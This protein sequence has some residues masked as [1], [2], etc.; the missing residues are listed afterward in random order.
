[1]KL[2]WSWI[3]V[4]GF[5][6]FVE[7]L[8]I[9]PTNQDQLPRPEDVQL[10][11]DYL[12]RFYNLQPRG[13]KMVRRARLMSPMEEKIRKMQK[14][15]GL[16]E[17]G[18]L[19]S[20]TLGV[21]KEP[22]CGVPDVE[23]FSFFSQKPKWKKHTITY[24]IAKYT[25]D[26]KREDV[27]NSF[28]SAM[29][30]W[31][32]A[33]LLRFI[34]VNQG[35]ADIVLSFARRTHGDFFPFDGPRGVLAHA[36]QPG[37]GIG[38]DV[39]FDED[40]T[41]TAGSGKQGYSLLAVAA[42]EL[43]HSLGLSHS[44]DPTAIMYPN[45]KYYSSTKCSLA[46][47]DVLGIQTLYGKPTKNVEPP[48][49]SRK[50]SR[51]CDPNFTLDAAAVI[52]NEIVFFKNRDMWMR[53]TWVTSWNRLTEG[54]IS[55][56]LPGISSHIDAAYDVPAKGIA[57]I[58]TG[59]KYWVVKQLKTKS[60]ARSIYEYGFSSRVRQVD[61]AVHVGEY[62]KTF[63][64]IG[65]VYYRYDELRRRMDP[66]FPRV[67]RSDWHGI[68]RTVEAGFKLHDSIYLFSGTKSYQYDFRQK[69]VVN[70]ISANA[71]LGC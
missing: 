33:T 65:E 5:L 6:M 52:G 31:R 40:E 55:T 44:N 62:G 13:R 35:K 17:T 64:F 57:Y 53:T 8:W 59:P 9:L 16:A 41:W 25:P 42:H 43:G 67:I 32:D 4:W 7:I 28:L 30:M 27:E 20:Q 1:M 63:F 11:E 51:K 49:I 19:D 26:M 12:Q 61:A 38:G 47:D 66:G 34:K 2:F 56:Y 21:M 70:R 60:H 24:K 23:N 58:F 46:E 37:E 50:N 18:H 15:F 36:F 3:R 69:R 29:K 71:W 48:I 45:Y 68:S 10:A 39:H 14:F 22:R 54:H